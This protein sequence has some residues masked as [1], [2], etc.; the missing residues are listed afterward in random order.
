MLVVPNQA[1]AAGEPAAIPVTVLAVIGQSEALR[2]MTILEVER[3]ERGQCLFCLARCQTSLTRQE[4]FLGVVN[5]VVGS[6]LQVDQGHNL[7][8]SGESEARGQYCQYLELERKRR[9]QEG[10]NCSDERSSKRAI[11]C[12]YRRALNIS[13]NFTDDELARN[14][15]GEQ[16]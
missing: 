15:E 11:N 10:Y 9:Q 7:M 8:V 2:G 5:G 3:C 16:T 14:H 12:H 4:Y 13:P 1:A 6:R